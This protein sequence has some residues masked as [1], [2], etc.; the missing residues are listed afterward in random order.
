MAGSF[1]PINKYSEFLPIASYLIL[2]D[3]YVQI[4][5]FV[6]A[7]QLSQNLLWSQQQILAFLTEAA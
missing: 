3:L 2:H 7:L 5:L 4:L 1:C 6:R